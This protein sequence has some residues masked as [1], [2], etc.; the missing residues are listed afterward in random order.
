MATMYSFEVSYF[1]HENSKCA[2]FVLHVTKSNPSVYLLCFHIF[3]HLCVVNPFCN[4][5]CAPMAIIW[6][7]ERERE[8][9]KVG[10]VCVGGEHFALLYAVV[11]LSYLINGC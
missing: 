4:V 5:C 9:K 7:S 10:H 1:P 11:L 8:S 6:K 2:Q 3:M